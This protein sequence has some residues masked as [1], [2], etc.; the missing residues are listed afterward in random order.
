M[1]II[2][3]FAALVLVFFG[4]SNAFSKN[5]S[6]TLEKVKLFQLKSSQTL[7]LEKDDKKS[8]TTLKSFSASFRQGPKPVLVRKIIRPL[9]LPFQNSFQVTDFLSELKISSNSDFNSFRSVLFGK[10]TIKSID[11]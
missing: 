8:F 7:K 4:Q 9:S 5:Y 1:T 3:P 10:I 11:F 6:S 2:K